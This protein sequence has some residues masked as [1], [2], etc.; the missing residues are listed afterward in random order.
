MIVGSSA[1]ERFHLRWFEAH[2]PKTGVAARPISTARL[3][4]ALAGPRSRELLARVANED[5]SAAALPFFSLRRMDVGCAPALV[6][7]VSFTGELGFEIY[8]DADYALAVY[9]SLVEAGPDL[10]LVHFGGRALNSLRLEKSF[11]AWLREYT[12]DYT[13][14]RPVWSG[15]STSTKATS[16]AAT[17]RSG[18]AM[19][20]P[21]TVSSPSWS[22]PPTL[23]PG[24][25]SRCSP[26]IGWSA[27]SPRAAMAT[28]SAQASRSPMSSPPSPRPMPDLV[29]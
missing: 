9:D 23:M 7:R 18:S 11:G 16:S 15:S 27:S 17:R 14:G 29:W 21:P 22:M 10:G 26:T 6:A 12:P 8:V 3:G 1:A 5:V 4:F 2:L 13:A 24:A 28:R 19:R 20:S 25:T